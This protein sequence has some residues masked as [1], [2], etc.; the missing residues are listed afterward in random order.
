MTST[1]PKSRCSNLLHS[2]HANVRWCQV[3]FSGSDALVAADDPVQDYRVVRDELRLYNPE[4]CMRPHVVALNKS[5]ML[6]SPSDSSR[7]VAQLQDLALQ[8]QV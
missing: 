5:D 6:E 4:Y 2:S 7:V 8:L 1:Q 3:Q